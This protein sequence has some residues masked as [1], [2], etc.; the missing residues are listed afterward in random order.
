M[1]MQLPRL[2]A[3]YQRTRRQRRHGFA[4]RAALEAHQARAWRRFE[5]DTLVR[6]PHFRPWRGLPLARWPLMDKAQMMRH[7]DGMNT[8]GLTLAEVLACAQEAERSRNFRPLVRG[9]GVGLSS[10]TSGGRGVFA[11]SA[12]NG[13]A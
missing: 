6:S 13:L 12:P 1:L 3:A 5:Q 7:F 11:V 10:G 4:S 2:L 8:A 9:Y